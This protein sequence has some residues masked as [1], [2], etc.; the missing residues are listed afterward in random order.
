M[1][2]NTA[3]IGLAVMTLSTASFVASGLGGS[4][5]SAALRTTS[6]KLCKEY[7]ADVAKTNYTAQSQVNSYKKLAKVAPAGLKSELVTVARE[8]QATINNGV[9]TSAKKSI[10]ALFSKIQSQ[11]NADCG[12]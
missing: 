6:S 9:T 3:K 8:E 12:K 7:S 5:A 4:A 11:L 1:K 10:E 2:I